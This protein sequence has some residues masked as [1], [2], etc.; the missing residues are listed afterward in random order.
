[1]KRLYTLISSLFLVLG[2]QAQLNADHN[3]LRV[4]DVIVKQ[5]VEFKTPGKADSHIIWDFSQ[6]KSIDNEYTL[7][8]DNA[9][10]IGDSIYIMGYHQFDKKVTPFEKLIVGTE[11]STMYYYYQTKDS[12]IL[13]GHENSLNKHENTQ[14]ITQMIHPLNYGQKTISEYKS[15]G[16]YSGVSPVSSEGE[17][18]IEADA[19][20]I[21]ILPSGDSINPVLRVKTEQTIY[22]TS[23]YDNPV[24]E[25]DKGRMMRSYKWYAKG[26]RYP[27]FETIESIALNNNEKL[28]TTAFFYPPQEHLYL[29]TDPENLALLEEYWRFTEKY[30]S[31]EGNLTDSDSKQRNYTFYPNPVVDILTIEYELEQSSPVNIIL[32]T[33]V[34]KV[35]RNINKEQQ[36]GKQMEYIDCS[37][38]SQGI[39]LLK[40]VAGD[41]VINEKIMKK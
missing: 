35:V 25:I 36:L 13:L 16:L 8:Y 30:A 22:D 39:Y 9:P 27:I 5:Q 3:S 41:L 34:G 40:L 33:V 24:V 26:Y 21:M 7:S 6:L 14:P 11:H 23:G 10:L 37:N 17:I 20:G 29:D 28:F 19:F 12:L 32:A 1:M 4:G 18:R 15:Q 31:E 38:L 2:L